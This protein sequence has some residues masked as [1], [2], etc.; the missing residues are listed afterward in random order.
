MSG[1]D[2]FNGNFSVVVRLAVNLDDDEVAVAANWEGGES[3]RLW[4]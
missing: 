1:F 4:A 3:F 2:G